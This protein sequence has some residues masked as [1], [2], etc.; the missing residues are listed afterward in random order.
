MAVRTL[1]LVEDAASATETIDEFGIARGPVQGGRMRVGFTTSDMKT[2]NAHFAGAKTIA[3]YEVS[4]SESAFV[5]AIQFDN[6]SA[7]SG[8]HD[9]D[10]EARINARIKALSGCALLFVTGIGG[11]AAAKVV[12]NNVHPVKLS[13][14]EPI[15]DV[16]ERV[17]TMMRGNPPPWLRKVM[18]AARGESGGMDFM[19]DDE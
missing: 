11:P 15:N 10:G 1:R 17:Q 6:A 14:P 16:I 12:R 2:V 3:V 7:Q 19:D 8:A 5:E 9:D 18:L 13:N 4:E